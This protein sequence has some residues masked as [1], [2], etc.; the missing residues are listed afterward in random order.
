MFS[1]SLQTK[2]SKT[3][4]FL[5]GSIFLFFYWLFGFDGITFSDDVYYLI[6]G[7]KFWEGTMQTGDFHFSSRWGAYVPAGFLGWILG[8]DPHRISL[9]SL[10][11]Y[12]GSLALLIKVLPK[13]SVTWVLVL[14]FGTQVYFLHFLTKVYPDSLLV[15]WV[16]LIP[17]SA[18]YRT[19]RP[20]LATLGLISGLFFGFITKETIVFLAPFPML[21]L[22]IDLKNK[23]INLRFY[24]SLF[25]FGLLFGLS[26]LGYFWVEFGDPL[27]RVTSINAGHYISEFTYADKGIWA[28]LK[29]ISYVPILTFVE[30]GYWLWVV[31]AIPGIWET[32]Q[33][34]I[35]TGLE[36]SL[37]AVC[38]LMG[39]WLMT[40]TL[41]FYNPIYLNPRHLIILVP[42]LAY[43][44]ALGW[45]KWE[46][47][48][49]LFRII[50]GL[51][52]LGVGISLF[53]LDWKMT[54]FQAG[55]LLWYSWRKMPL[56]ST[57]LLIL[58]LAP[59][60]FSIAYQ[61]RVKAYSGLIES[62]NE[63]LQNPDNHKPILTHNFLHFS[64]EV[65]F[66]EDSAS[67]RRILP[68][69]K[70]D[71]LR[72]HLPDQMDVL[73]YEYYKHAYPKEQVDVDALEI[74]L[75][76]NFEL[77]QES[78]KDLIWLRSFERRK[79]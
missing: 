57:V 74:Y 71:S 50:L 31:M 40:S 8:F 11:A 75:E 16:V 10:L 32:W 70:L 17:F 26:Y 28:I 62:L 61:G 9:I 37:A 13:S 63:I 41:N 15:F 58:L 20:I 51:I 3:A 73:I 23:Q 54:A 47:D 12:V 45:R 67:Q 22:L 69:E 48:A 33:A 38:L 66:P 34:K 24:A 42:I 29:R 35:K 1:E 72:P 7:K 27:Y 18:C 76:E 65:L 36:F 44:I 64:R 4:A 39:F 43:L 30:R 60:L 25:G 59:A 56:K 2:N 77:V 21:L 53:Q 68:I 14:W 78:K 19:Q 55:F 5:T 52:L 46:S 6:A 79:N 49:I